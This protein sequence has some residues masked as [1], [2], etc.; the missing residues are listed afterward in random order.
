VSDPLGRP[1]G[2]SEVTKMP[3]RRDWA[4]WLLTCDVPGRRLRRA[5]QCKDAANVEQENHLTNPP[6]AVLQSPVVRGKPA[7]QHGRAVCAGL[8]RLRCLRTSTL[9]RIARFRLLRYK[10]RHAYGSC[11]GP[12]AGCRGCGPCPVAYR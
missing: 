10:G 1:R 5:G 12:G 8:K 9:C 3:A 2:R 4:L 7:G 6:G 11:G